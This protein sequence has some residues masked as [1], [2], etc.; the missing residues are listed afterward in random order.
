MIVFLLAFISGCSGET[1]CDEYSIALSNEFESELFEDKENDRDGFY[2]LAKQ[3]Q[4]DLGSDIEAFES[5]NSGNLS[6]TEKDH[7][8]EKYGPL[9]LMMAISTGN[10][11]R[12]N[13]YLQNGVDSLKY[14]KHLGVIVLDLV[15]I[16]DRELFSV[17]DS[18]F[19][20]NQIESTVFGEIELYYKECL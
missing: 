16:K 12:T 4:A 18:F 20:D 15:E 7:I 17:F 8:I 11:E 13:F 6:A 2:R 9:L 14:H 5:L 1:D 10:A 3:M 19:H